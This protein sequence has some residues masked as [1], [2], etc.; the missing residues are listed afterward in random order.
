MFRNFA[1]NRNENDITRYV[2]DENNRLEVVK[3]EEAEG[4]RGILLGNVHL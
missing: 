2:Q 3:Q 4:Q 1:P